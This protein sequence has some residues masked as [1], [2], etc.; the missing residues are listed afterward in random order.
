ML[1][2]SKPID[3]NNIPV[4]KN[5]SKDVTVAKNIIDILFITIN[6][7]IKNDPKMS[8]FTKSLTLGQ[9]PKIRDG[10]KEHL[11]K[12]NQPKVKK[13]LNEIQIE[14]NKR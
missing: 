12:M 4:Y 3:F 7:N 5:T 14:L 13:L 11:D 6:D 9:L 2:F 10:S 1:N 8:G